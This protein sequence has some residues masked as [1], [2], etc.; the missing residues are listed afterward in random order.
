MQF[1]RYSGMYSKKGD[2][3][4][5]NTTMTMKKTLFGNKK[6]TL[7]FLAVL[8][9]CLLF[10]LF[11][12]ANTVQAA[13]SANTA[14]ESASTEKKLK[15]LGKMCN[16]ADE[17][18]ITVGKDD[19]KSELGV[20]AG[21]AALAK[22]S[23]AYAKNL[24]A[25]YGYEN[26]SG[27]TYET[28]YPFS[29]IIVDG[30]VTDSDAASSVTDSGVTILQYNSPEEAALASTEFESEG[31]D[32]SPDDILATE[33]TS[34]STIAESTPYETE[35][36][37]LADNSVAGE[38]EVIVTV[39]DSGIEISALGEYSD[40]I[41]EGFNSAHS[42][43]G[44]SDVSDETDEEEL[45]RYA[46]EVLNAYIGPFVD[47]L[48]ENGTTVVCSAGNKSRDASTQFP[49]S[50]SPC[51]TISAIDSSFNFASFSSGKGSNY[52][53]VVD[54]CVPGKDITVIN[55]EGTLTTASGTSFS[56][57]LVAACAAQL[58]SAGGKYDADYY[59]EG[60]KKK[61]DTARYTYFQNNC[62][63][64]GL[65]DNADYEG[66]DF[67]YGFGLVTMTKYNLVNAAV[68]LSQDSY[69]YTGSS[70]KPT[71]TVSFGDL[72]LSKYIH[73]SVSYSN[74]TNIGT[75]TVT[76]SGLTS[77]TGSQTISYTINPEKPTISSL[78]STASRK[79]T[80][81]YTQSNQGGSAYRIYYR[82]AGSSSWNCAS[83]GNKSYTFTWLT[84]GAAYEFRVRAYKTVSGTTYCSDYSST[85]TVTII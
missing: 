23:K 35:Y 32:T 6:M 8:A 46:Q 1:D 45:I 51:W 21:Q 28:Q 70:K 82:K 25:E 64:L 76:V 10:V 22:A 38:E 14:K 62:L 66:C 68:S 67:Y 7:A 65:Q 34:V 33:D 80:I 63:D 3:N 54:F 57:P 59:S 39:I 75:A 53:S 73:Y 5:M 26:V 60:N 20:S 15:L 83:T 71:V 55:S 18:T 50:Y 44:D 74:Y 2:E 12:G 24:L 4:I 27:N 85:E 78:T 61:A 36:M 72:D 81:T 58:T 48:I 17:K 42:G 52:G 56:A 40:R 16:E 77:C 30:T 29:R 19:L 84:S 41:L 11:T 43:D 31:Y 37:H 79:A 9:A 69:T 13:T 47:S 49:A